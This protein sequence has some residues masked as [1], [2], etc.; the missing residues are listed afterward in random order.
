MVH[1]GPFTSCFFWF[2]LPGGSSIAPTRVILPEAQCELS[3]CHG[4]RSEKCGGDGALV[5][6]SFLCGGEG[7]PKELPSF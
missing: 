6:Y 5:V 3:T 4:N 7:F 2:F 1:L